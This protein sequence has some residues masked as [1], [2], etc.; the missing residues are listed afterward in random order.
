MLMLEGDPADHVFSI[1]SGGVK[2]YKSLPD[3]RQQIVACLLPGD[4]LTPPDS[5]GYVFSAE[6]LTETEFCEFPRGAFDRVVRK[7]EKLKRHMQRIACDELAAAHEH[8]LVLGRKNAL[9][10]LC[11]FLVDLRARTAQW[12]GP[13]DPLHVPLQRTEIADYLGLSMET[14]S[15]AFSRMRA[16]GLIRIPARPEEICIVDLPRVE[17]I[18]NGGVRREPGTARPRAVTDG[19]AAPG[20]VPVFPDAGI[21]R[22]CCGSAADTHPCVWRPAAPFF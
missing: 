17:A 11:S 7:Y 15:R 6:A 21:A 20:T 2:L 5:G 12:G 22:P 1:V 4:C 9:E 14:V 3:G 19:E 8:M 16:L 18:A 13:T 10:R